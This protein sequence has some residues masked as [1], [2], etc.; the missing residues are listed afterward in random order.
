VLADLMRRPCAIRSRSELLE[1]AR[2]DDETIDER[3]IDAHI[4]RIRKKLR[5]IQPTFDPL[6]SLY[7]IGYR[8]RPLAV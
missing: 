1:V 5:A 7:G 8:L 3:A 4:K 2:R 6:E